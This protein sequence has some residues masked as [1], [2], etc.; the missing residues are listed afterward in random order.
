MIDGRNRYR[1]CQELGVEPPARYLDY[2]TDAVDFVLSAN[3]SRP[4]LATGQR[5]MVMAAVPR[6]T[7][8]SDRS[9]STRKARA[10]RGGVHPDTQRMADAIQDYGDPDRARIAKAA[11]TSTIQTKSRQGRGAVPPLDG[12]PAWSRGVQNP[13]RRRQQ[14]LLALL[15]GERRILRQGRRLSNRCRYIFCF[16]YARVAYTPAVYGLDLSRARG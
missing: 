1:A 16:T 12:V 6:H 11:S 10:A 3:I 2:D 5:A 7:V 15:R 8:D 13:T 9:L 4:N 14:G